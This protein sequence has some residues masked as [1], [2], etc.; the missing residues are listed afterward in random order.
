MRI[1][2]PRGATA[3]ATAGA[4]PTMYIVRGCCAFSAGLAPEETRAMR[5]PQEPQKA[6]LGCTSFPQFG[7]GISPA[8]AAMGSPRTAAIGTA[9]VLLSTGP[10]V[11]A[12]DSDRGAGRGAAA[13]A[14]VALSGL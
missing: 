11:G 7:Q 3:G 12:F 9:G 4:P 2:R 8:G 5:V 10:G 1:S 6:K 13:P 14:G